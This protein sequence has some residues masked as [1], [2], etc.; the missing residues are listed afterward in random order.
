MKG[1]EM[2]T[3]VLCINWNASMEDIKVTSGAILY[4]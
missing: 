3:D 2:L 4:T 1:E